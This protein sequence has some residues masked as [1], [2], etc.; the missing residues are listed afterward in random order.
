M[1]APAHILRYMFWVF[2]CASNS[3]LCLQIITWRDIFFFLSYY[4]AQLSLIRFKTSNKNQNLNSIK[5]FGNFI[6]TAKSNS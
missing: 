6:F 3:M 2:E 5:C 1:T 4:K